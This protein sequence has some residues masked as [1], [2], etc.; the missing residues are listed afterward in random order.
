MIKFNVRFL[1]LA[2]AIAASATFLVTALADSRSINFEAPTYALGTI[3][4]Q[5]GWSSLGAAGMGCAAYD[6]FV[7]T[8]IGP[9][10]FGAQSLRISNAVTSQ[11]FGDQT[12]SAPTA[13]EAGES[14]ATNGGM[15]GGVRGDFFEYT[16]DFASTMAA[17]QAGMGV[18][19]SADR[20]DGARM[21]WTRVDDAPGGLTVSFN[22]YNATLQDFNTTAVVAYGLDRTTAHNLRVTVNFVEGPANDVVKVYVDGGLVYTGTTWEDYFRDYEAGATSR[23]VDSVL[24][25]T[26]GTNA[27]A[28]AGNGFLFDNLSLKSGRLAANGVQCKNGGWQNF[29]RSDGSTFNNQG[30]CVSY[31]KNGK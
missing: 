29:V 6:H 19:L 21:T 2:L 1:A 22:D 7:S 15:S 30:D 11:C 13:N 10:S 5:D 23:T 28:T 8:N 27:P 12:F 18:T 20:G 14:T 26:G 16:V 3:N 24:F 9:S 17:Y 31:T 4:A 25:R